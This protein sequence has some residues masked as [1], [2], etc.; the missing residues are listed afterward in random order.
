MIFIIFAKKNDWLYD[1]SLF[2]EMIVMI[3]RDINLWEICKYLG[4]HNLMKNGL[5]NVKK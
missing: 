4:W 3:D 2:K 1:N 5:E